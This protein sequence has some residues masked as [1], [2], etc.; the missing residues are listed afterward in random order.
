MVKALIKT[1]AF[2]QNDLDNQ[3]KI[4]SEH[5]NSMM[6][7]MFGKDHAGCSIEN[8]VVVEAWQEQMQGEQLRL[9]Q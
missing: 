1:L 8:G 4:L 5:R 6:W 2:I 7:L 3:W 9:L